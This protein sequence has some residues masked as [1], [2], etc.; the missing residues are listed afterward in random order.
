MCTTELGK[1]ANLM[2]E[3]KKRN[4]KVMALS[5]DTVESHKKWIPDI[6]ET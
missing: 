4:C 6:E 5:I 1:V 2:P 3:F